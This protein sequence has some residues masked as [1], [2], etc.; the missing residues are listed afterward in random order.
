MSKKQ[1]TGRG[2]V[3][4]SLYGYLYGYGPELGGLVSSGFSPWLPGNSGW[5]K[6]A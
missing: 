1:I 5:P 3:L 4:R 6:K 2:L